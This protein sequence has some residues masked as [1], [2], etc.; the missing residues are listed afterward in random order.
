MGCREIISIAF[1]AESVPDFQ[2]WIAAV[3][4]FWLVMVVIVRQ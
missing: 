2:D 4:M 3:V 1:W